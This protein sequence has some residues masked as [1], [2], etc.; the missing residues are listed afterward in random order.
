MMVW[1]GRETETKEYRWLNMKLRQKPQEKK[2]LE[3]IWEG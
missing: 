1:R 2:K 3:N